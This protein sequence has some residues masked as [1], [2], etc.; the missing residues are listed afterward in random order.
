HATLAAAIDASFSTLSPAE[1]DALVQCAVFRGG[2]TLEAAVAVVDLSTHAGAGRGVPPA[3]VDVLQTLRE[4]SL[5]RAMEPQGAPGE[6]RAPRA[7]GGL[8]VR[9]AARV[10]RARARSGAVRDQG[11]GRGS[12]AVGARPVRARGAPA[13]ARRRARGE[14]RSGAGARGGA[15]ARRRG[16]RS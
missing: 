12:E 16:A 4:K 2:F 7:R 6:V 14:P 10:V 1:Q 8:A 9:R 3:V 5:L 15:H 13:L 11:L